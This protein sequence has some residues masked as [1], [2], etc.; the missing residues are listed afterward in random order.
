MQTKFYGFLF[1]AF[2]TAFASPK[3]F[4]Q[5]ETKRSHIGGFRME[6]GPGYS[7]MN[8]ASL[9]SINSVLNA[10]GYA[11]AAND[12]P[13]W[14]MRF[15]I[16]L[17][18]SVLD[19]DFNF[20]LKR[21]LV[22]DN[23]RTTTTGSFI[24]I[25]YGYMF[26]AGKHIIINPSLGI[27]FGSAGIHSHLEGTPVNDV[28]ATNNF[29]M[30]DGSLGFDYMPHAIPD[31]SA[32]MNSSNAIGKIFNGNYGITV[33]AA[34]SPYGSFWNDNNIDISSTHNPNVNFVAN[35]VGI[36]NLAEFSLVYVKLRLGIGMVFRGKVS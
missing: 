27:D 29:Y 22:L 26:P 10:S 32:L 36:N 23:S 20:F 15:P 17:H 31:A 11:S 7:Y 35:V 18:N 24:K 33:G 2:I 12:F 21:N 28:S 1:I 9:H 16:I 14:N 3:L 8:P 19:F 4:S 34:F 6:F 13:S 25:G 30:L 5:E